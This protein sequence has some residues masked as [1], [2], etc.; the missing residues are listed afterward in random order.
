MEACKL[1]AAPPFYIFC[2]K[3]KR[4]FK[5]AL[6]LDL[7]ELLEVDQDY[8]VI[9]TNKLDSVETVLDFHHGR[10]SQEGLFSELKSHNHLD[11]IPSKRWYGNQAYL[12]STL[13][14]HNLNR[15]LQMFGTDPQRN[16]S[17]KHAALW[18]FEKLNTQRQRLI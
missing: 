16:P 10:G 6:Q 17:A 1:V 8:N 5:G 2:Q 12:L 14:A 4:P 11:Y 15:E 9:L 7:F 18:R 3:V 13:F